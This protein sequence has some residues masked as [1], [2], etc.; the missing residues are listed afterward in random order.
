MTS[1]PCPPRNIPVSAGHSYFHAAAI[2]GPTRAPDMDNRTASNNRVEWG[3]MITLLVIISLAFAVLIEPFFGAV[4]WGVVVAVLFRPVYERLLDYLPGRANLVAAVTL[5]LILLLV[6]VPTILLGMAL[7]QEAA[8]I[9]VRIQEGEIDFGAVFAAFENSLPQW[10]QNQLAAYGY[11]DFASIRAEI[12][13]SITAILEFLVTQLLSVGQG[14][15]QFMLGL[16][17]ML[18]L[19]FFLLRDGRA[20]SDRIE[21]M[22][23]LGEEKRRILM[24][25]FLVVIRATIKGSL[26]IAIIQGSLGGLVFWALDIR[27]A[28]LWAVLMGIFSLIPAIG[29]GFVWVPVALYLFITGDI[30][31]AVVLVLCGVFVISMVDNLVRPTLVGRDTRM[32]DYVVLISTLGGL[33][34]FGINGIVIGPL[35]AALFIAIWSIFSDMQAGPAEPE[36]ASE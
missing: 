8:T 33:Q 23:P 5:I 28:L 14:A 22:V 7:A 34:L 21:Q 9:Y 30:W 16:G 26:I 27:G 29:T 35:V 3:F 6:I 11:G 13:Q 1:D 32:P 2:A 31:Q 19:T 15:F 12:E 10:V 36:K 4:V 20:L 24:D 25:K 18:Y 17:V